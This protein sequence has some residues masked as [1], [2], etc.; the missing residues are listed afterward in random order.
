MPEAPPMVF[1]AGGIRSRAFRQVVEKTLLDLALAREEGVWAAM[2]GAC[3]RFPGKPALLV[4]DLHELTTSPAWRR[5]TVGPSAV[6]V[7][8]LVRTS[9]DE[10]SLSSP[11]VAL[12]VREDRFFLLDVKDP[13]RGAPSIADTLRDYFRVLVAR[14]APD[15]VLAAKYSPVD[16]V[17]W[18]EFGDGLD[19]AIR[20]SGLP[21]ADRLGFAPI[22]AA[23][24]EHG[25][26]VLL[27]DAHDA[28]VDISAGSLRAAVD[29]RYRSDLDKED[30]SERE[31]IGARIRAVREGFGL[32]QDEVS[33][34]SGIAQESLSRIEKGR[35]EPRLDTLRKLAKGF[36]LSLA[37]LL[38]ELS[39]GERTGGA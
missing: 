20:W 10:A 25:Q 21:F 19:R 38:E 23:A 8:L 37:Q 2:T 27:R 17:L 28:E 3:P 36:G 7:V 31:A 5:E 22:A 24:R 30:E 13:R 14:L 16:E 12:R 34:R 29:P 11:D 9:L 1:D 35:R 6:F 33:R 39:E 26:S 32:S 15:R 4:S 18:V